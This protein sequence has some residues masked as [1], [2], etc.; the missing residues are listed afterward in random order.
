MKD[1]SARLA[2]FA[3]LDP[4]GIGFE[5]GPAFFGGAAAIVHQDVDDCIWRAWLVRRE[6]VAESGQAMPLENLDHGITEKVEEVGQ[7]AGLGGIRADFENALLGIFLFRGEQ[8]ELWRRW[9]RA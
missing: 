6:P 7:L 3:G 2:F 1:F 4:L 5:V 8:F 9:R